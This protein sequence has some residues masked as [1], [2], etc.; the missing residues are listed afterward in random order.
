MTE[1][2]FGKCA[3]KNLETANLST[4]S[5]QNKPRQQSACRRPSANLPTKIGKMFLKDLAFVL[6]CELLVLVAIQ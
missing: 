1:N 4:E 2:F 3:N 5:C 6:P